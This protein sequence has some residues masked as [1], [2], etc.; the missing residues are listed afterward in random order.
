MRNNRGFTIIELAVVIVIIA[1][2]STIGFIS[3]NGAQKTARDSKRKIDV[4]A[5]VSAY[6]MHYVD[7]K[8]WKFSPTELASINPDAIGEGAGGGNGYFN[9]EAAPPYLVSMATALSTLGYLPNKPIDPSIP[10]DRTSQV[11]KGSPSVRVASQ[12]MKYPCGG[13]I[14]VEAMLENVP[15]PLDKS[16]IP[17]GCSALF[18]TLNSLYS[19]NYAV[20]IK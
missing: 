3:Y 6:Q 17:P 5:I 13:G 7:T 11:S 10:N 2:L 12:Y 19:V 15:S 16:Q 20:G 14:I 18:D 1:I 4:N 8:T 9:Y